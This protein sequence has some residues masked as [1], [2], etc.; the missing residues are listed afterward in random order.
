MLPKKTDLAPSYELLAEISDPFI[1]SNIQATE[2]IVS[3][4]DLAK[5]DQC[6][7]NRGSEHEPVAVLLRIAIYNVLRGCPTP[8]DW[9][10][11]VQSCK[12]GCRT[13]ARAKAITLLHVLVM[14]VKT[15]FN[16]R[17]TK[18]KAE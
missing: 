11:N 6:Y 9:A 15:L 7:S 3:Q 12:I 2:D 5:L 14:N 1:L 18:E 10:R 16:L 13:P 17:R 8:S 4:F